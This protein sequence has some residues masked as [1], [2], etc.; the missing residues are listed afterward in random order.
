MSTTE[1][2]RK[3]KRTLLD[4]DGVHIDKVDNRVVKLDLS[5]SAGVVADRDRRRKQMGTGSGKGK[6]GCTSADG[7]PLFEGQRV[8]NGKRRKR[9]TDHTET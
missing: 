6:N 9:K 1:I 2:E 8:S 4:S 5:R 7:P 3:P